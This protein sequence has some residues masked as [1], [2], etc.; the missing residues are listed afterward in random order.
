[1]YIY[2]Y[3]YIHRERDRERERERERWYL[4]DLGGARTWASGTRR[5]LAEANDHNNCLQYS[6]SKSNNC[7]N[8]DSH[9]VSDNDNYVHDIYIYTYI[10]IYMYN[11]YIYIF[12]HQRRRRRSWRGAAGAADAGGRHALAHRRVILYV[13][14]IKY[15]VYVSL[16]IDIYI[17][18]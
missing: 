9:S 8:S 6:N 15:I 10:Y 17:Y 12:R 4:Y 1:M 2:I 14:H 16:S 3:I 13:L 11:I 7:H 5:A 18:I